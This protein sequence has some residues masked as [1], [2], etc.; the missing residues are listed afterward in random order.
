MWNDI[1]L[2]SKYTDILGVETFGVVFNHLL[3]DFA[4]QLKANEKKFFVSLSKEIH[5]FQNWIILVKLNPIVVF[6]NLY[7]SMY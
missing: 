4:N 2:T 6:W 3:I 5:E 1:H 7:T